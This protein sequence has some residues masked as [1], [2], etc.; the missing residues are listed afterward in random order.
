MFAINSSIPSKVL[1]TPEDIEV[2]TV[3]ITMDNSLNLCPL[4]NPPYSGS[5]Y[6]QHLLSYLTSLIQSDFPTVIMGDLNA[7]DIYWS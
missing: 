3:Q 1:P 6:Q 7:P 2:L 4:Y 5:D